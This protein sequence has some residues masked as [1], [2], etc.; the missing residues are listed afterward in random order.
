[1]SQ[2]LTVNELLADDEKVRRFLAWQPS[3]TNVVMFCQEG[4]SGYLTDATSAAELATRFGSDGQYP[5]DWDALGM[6]H[7]ILFAV[8]FDSGGT[9]SEHAHSKGL[10]TRT[11]REIDAEL[12]KVLQS[13]VD[14]FV[15]SEEVS[16]PQAK[17]VDL[18]DIDAATVKS[19]NDA[20]LKDLRAGQSVP[21]WQAGGQLILGGMQSAAWRMAIERANGLDPNGEQGNGLVTM[22]SRGGALSSGKISVSGKYDRDAFK[23]A[24]REFSN[25]DIDFT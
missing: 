17:V 14:S 13:Y 12:R 4:L 16:Q 18:A 11:F 5:I 8:D 22:V 15:F 6:E 20:V 21:F 9:L 24:I 3:L 2:S 19:M 23:S 1:M 10:V 7:M 25:K